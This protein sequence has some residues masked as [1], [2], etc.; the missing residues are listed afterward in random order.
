[1]LKL[2]S[3]GLLVPMNSELDVSNVEQNTFIP[4]HLLYAGFRLGWVKLS[5]VCMF[6][7]S[8]QKAAA[9]GDSFTTQR[10]GKS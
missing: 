4:N 9:E 8:K 5:R 6:L 10:G 1:M 2:D 3:A 7:G